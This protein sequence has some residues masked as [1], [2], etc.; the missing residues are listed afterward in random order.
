METC[1][2]FCLPVG[3]GKCVYFLNS[4]AFPIHTKIQSKYFRFASLAAVFEIVYIFQN[5][6]WFFVNWFQQG[7]HQP[8][9]YQQLWQQPQN[10]LSCAV[11]RGTVSD[12][13][14]SN[15]PC[16]SKY[17]YH[18]IDSDNSD[19]ESA[20]K[21]AS[22]RQNLS[23]THPIFQCQ[24]DLYHLLWATILMYLRNCGRCKYGSFI[25]ITEMQFVK[26]SSP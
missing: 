8:P 14:V 20:Q 26:A 5:F 2:F 15:F 19:S 1:Y 3:S 17:H 11:G 16:T 6:T 23:S 18:S 4:T 25:G 7:E 10:N 9:P 12:Q 21:S 22:I 13:W 24:I